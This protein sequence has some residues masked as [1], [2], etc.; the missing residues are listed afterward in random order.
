MGLS[1]E[2]NCSLASSL[3]SNWR[4]QLWGLAL[5]SVIMGDAPHAPS[6]DLVPASPSCP[7]H[8]SVVTYTWGP[9]TTQLQAHP[10]AATCGYSVGLPGEEV[11]GD[12]ATDQP[13]SEGRK[14][15]THRDKQA[16]PLHCATCQGFSNPLWDPRSPSR[17]CSPSG[18]VPGPG[19]PEH[20]VA[21]A[22]PMQVS[23][24][25]GFVQKV[26]FQHRSSNHYLLPLPQVSGTFSL[27]S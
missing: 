7:A 15:G 25:E 23:I 13:R 5:A 24:C 3:S 17:Q 16:S 11:L 27:P 1:R 8:L 20:S 21:A 2:G 4:N 12:G 18:V 26:P 10:I 19:M 22:A 9:S 14:P 6:C